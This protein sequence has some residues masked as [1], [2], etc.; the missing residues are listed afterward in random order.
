MKSTQR[1]LKRIVFILIS[2]V[3]CVLIFNIVLF[4]LF[5]WNEITA[6]NIKYDPQHTIVSVSKSLHLENGKF[7]LAKS[8]ESILKNQHIWAMLIDNHTGSVLWSRS[9]PSNIKTSYTMTD[10]A[11]FSKSYLKDYPVFVWEHKNGLLVLGYPKNSYWKFMSNYTE[12]SFIRSV[13][14]NTLIFIL[15]NLGL[16]L[17]IYM[18]ANTSLLRSVNPIIDGIEALPA[19]KD[20]YVKEKGSLSEIASCIN[21]TA[22]SLKHKNYELK[23]KD[24]ARANWIAGVSHDIRT[25]LSMVLGYASKLENSSEL[26]D[27]LKR[28]ASIIRIQ[29]LKMRNLINDLN[30]ASK[31]EYNMQPVNLKKLNLAALIRQVSADFLNC[32]SDMKYPIE[33]NIADDTNSLFVMGDEP[34]LK[35][36]V[37]NII[38]NS[39]NHNTHG[40]KITISLN[41]INDY[42]EIT[43][44]DDGCGVSHEK[45]ESLK[46]APHYMVCDSST[47]NQR[48]GLGLLIVKQ[49][50]KVHKGT[51]NIE[52]SP[53]NGFK[54][55]LKLPVL[56]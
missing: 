47:T 54:S 2:S 10:I 56:K 50:I 35:R 36:A 6:K 52:S 29:S 18:I 21:K 55:I 31:L 4:A 42:L 8:K 33:I 28:Q 23:K 43:I 19:E 49:I 5:N 27:N 38:Q 17:I 39:M 3:F 24:E 26:S 46:N 13:P 11:K 34:L 15:A 32:S 7:V 37:N 51:F 40:C 20:I 25:P 44:S 22:M 14:I 48:H 30:L 41:R 12:V 9:L 1:L 16:I 45:L 53:K